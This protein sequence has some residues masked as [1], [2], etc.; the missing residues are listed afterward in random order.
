MSEI[1]NFENMEAI[2]EVNPD[3]L[4]GAAGGRSR[5]PRLP[6]KE[7]YIQYQIVPGDTLIRIAQRYHTTVDALM[8]YNPQITKRNLIRA[9]AYMYIK[10]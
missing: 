2:V 3:E 8:S 10:I 4:E 5:Y 7:G 9:G 1:E 6:A